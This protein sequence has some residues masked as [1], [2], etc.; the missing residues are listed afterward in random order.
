M[1]AQRRII[2]PRKNLD[3]GLHSLS[4][5]DDV[6]FNSVVIDEIDEDNDVFTSTPTQN[7]VKRLFLDMVPHEEPQGSDPISM[8]TELPL[9]ENRANEN[10]DVNHMEVDSSVMVEESQAEVNDMVVED[11]VRIEE[12]DDDVVSI[13]RMDDNSY[14]VNYVYKGSSEEED[15]EFKSKNVGGLSVNILDFMIDEND[16]DV[17][18]NEEVDSDFGEDNDLERIR[19]CKLRQLRKRKLQED[20]AVNKH[21]FFKCVVD[22]VRKTCSCMRWEITWI[23]WRHAFVANWNMETNG[24]PVGIGRRELERQLRIQLLRMRGWLGDGRLLNVQLMETWVTISNHVKVKVEFKGKGHHLEQVSKIKVKEKL[25]KSLLASKSKRVAESGQGSGGAF[26]GENNQRVM[27]AFD[28]PIIK[29]LYGINGGINDDRALSHSTWGAILSSV[30]RLKQYG[31]DLLDLCTRKTGNGALTSF[32]N[33]SCF[34]IASVRTLIDANTLVVDSNATRWIRCVPIKINI[35]LWRLVLNKLPTRVNLE[36]KGIDVDSTLCH[37]CGED[38]ETVNHIFF[39]CE[40]VKDLWA[41]LARWWSLDIPICSNFLDWSSWLDSLH[42]SSKVKLFLEGEMLHISNLDR[43]YIFTGTSRAKDPSDE[44]SDRFGSVFNVQ[45]ANVFNSFITNAGLEEV[46]LGGS[47]FTWCHKSASKMSKLDRFLV[48]ENLIYSCPNINAITLERYLSDHRPI[49]LREASFDYGPTP[50]RYFHYWNEME[51]FNKVVEDAWREGPCDKTNAMLNMMMKLKF[52]KAKIREWN[53][54]NML[55]VKNVKAKYKE[56]L[57]ALE[58]IID[59]G[60][61]NEEIVNKRTEVVNNIQKFDKIHSS[62]MA[63]KAKVKWSIEGDENTSFFHGVL[64]KKRSILNIRG[65]M[66]DG[67]WIESPKAVKGEF[68]QHF[69]S[70]F[71]KPDASRATINMRYPK[72]LTYDQQNELE[73]EVSN[74]EIKRA[75]WDCGTDKS[76]GPDGFTFGFYRRFWKIIENDVYDAVKYFFTYGNIPKGCNSSFIALIPKI[77]DANMVKDF[78]PIS[79]IGSLYKIIAKILAN[80]LVGVLGDI[81]NEVQSAFIAERQILDGPFIL[82]EILQWSK[83]KKKQ[84]LIFKVDFEKA[85]DSVRWDFLDDILK[86]FGFGEKWCKWIQSCLRSSRG[87]ILINGSPTE[88]FQFYKGLK[89]GDPLSPFLFILIMESLHLSFQRVVDNGMFNGIKLSSSLSISHLFYADDAVFMGQWCDGNISTLIHVL[90]CFYR[91]SGLRINM[92]KSKILGV[93]VDSDK[94]KGA[95][96]K[97]GCLILKTPFTYLGSKVGGSMSRVHAWNEVIDRVKNRLSKWKMKTLSI[98]GRLTLL[99]SVLGSIP[100]FHM[101][102]YRAPLSVLRTLESIRSKNFKGHDINSNKASWVN[103]KK[104][105]ASKEKGGLGVSSL[106]ALNRGL[107]FK[108]IWRFYTQNTLLWVRVV[109]AIHGDDG[110]VGGHVKSGAKSCWLD[111]VRETHALKTK[112]IN[113]LDC[114]HVKLGNGDKTVFW[115][116]IWIDG[117]TLKNRFPRIYSLE[118]C[119]LI[120]VGAKLAQPSL[121]YSFRRNP[122]GGVEQDQFNELSALVH[123]VSLIPM[124]DR[125]KWDLESSG[126]FSVASVRKIIDDKSLSDVD[127]K[128]RWIK[129]VPIKVNVHAWK[130]KTDSLPTRFNVSRRGIDI[131]SIMCAICDNGVETSRHLFFYCCMVRQI[132]RKITRWWD[133]P[134]VEVESYEDWYNWLVN[135]RISSMHK[136]MFEGV[137]YVMWWHLWSFRN[138]LIF[139]SKPP[140]Q[141]LFFDDV[142]S[143]SF[144]WCRKLGRI[145]IPEEC[146]SRQFNRSLEKVCVLTTQMNFIKEMV[147]API[148]SESIPVRI[149]KVDGEI[150]SLFN[151][152]TLTSSIFGGS[153]DDIEDGDDS[154]EDS[155]VNSKEEDGPLGATN[156]DTFLENVGVPRNSDNGPHILSEKE[157]T[158]NSRKQVKDKTNYL[159]ECDTMLKTAPLNVCD[160]EGKSN[161]PHLYQNVSHETLSIPHTHVV[162]LDTNFTISDQTLAQYLNKI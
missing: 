145:L 117:K 131:D 21:D 74:V 140:S 55:S 46:P 118:S 149:S 50:F 5:D 112:G 29:I 94:V 88:E 159:H 106:F 111:I 121:E 27:F 83:T 75:V 12:S 100:I 40:M 37:I 63:Q 19:N 101:S 122:R 39:S 79:L 81:V 31:I 57:E 10:Q 69:S 130:V 109:K 80:R 30:K 56:E 136:Q 113:L 96:S 23:P 119:K 53:K 64:N 102:I 35:F 155:D 120:T 141:A 18:D 14:D 71:D 97:L 41:L 147:H 49:L 73:S 66:V 107:M 9:Q 127:S 114:M 33:D 60:D 1:H 116:D 78:R 84:S 143:M 99:K 103:W 152:Y 108:W 43:T 34:T 135:L 132:V 91:A 134:Y 139:D 85:Y 146:S 150:D 157:S 3:I 48:S 87:S 24:Q 2:V 77:P 126:D 144:H 26:S 104:V 133:V 62:E 59:R 58:A 22:V 28:E 161:L 65:I 160:T 76:P 54:S 36:R 93:N 47:A 20:G 148:G 45:G 151:G 95:A 138:K 67:N 72:T 38:V 8:F 82:N 13:D 154:G 68:F 42:L 7:F 25:L 158:S 70:R 142:V 162:S 11:S 156:K 89:Q 98:G 128:T 105:L 137:F 17:I 153:N 6:R 32:W 15:N 4:C 125:W 129:Y 123:D 44:I 51:G 90:E 52:L 92:S 86:K 115:E 124:S 61:G 16:L 110:N